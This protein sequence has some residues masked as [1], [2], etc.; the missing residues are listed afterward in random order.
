MALLQVQAQQT[1]VFL[2]Q[3]QENLALIVDEGE[4]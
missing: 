3:R 1:P 2:Q 4:D